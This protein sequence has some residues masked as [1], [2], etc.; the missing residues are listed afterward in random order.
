[1]KYSISEVAAIMD[2]VEYREE[3][4]RLKNIL[5]EL[6]ASGIVVVFGASD[7]LMEFRGAIYDELGAWNGATA[8]LNGLG[9]VP[10]PSCVLIG[11]DLDEC[12]FYQSQKR[13]AAKIKALWRGEVW[14]SWTYKT[15]IPHATF[16]VLENNEPYCRGIVFSLRDVDDA[17]ESGGSKEIPMR[18]IYAAEKQRKVRLDAMSI[19]QAIREMDAK[20]FCPRCNASLKEK[21]NYCGE[22]GQRLL[23]EGNQ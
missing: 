22:C 19:M 10:N 8:Y 11:N 16:E 7:D 14:Y 2:G 3:D 15:D 17:L 13:C 23:W 1:M 12:T 9:L 5:P 4:S 21:P 20:L 18:P 6:K